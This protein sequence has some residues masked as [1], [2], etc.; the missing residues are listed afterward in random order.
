MKPFSNHRTRRRIVVTLL[1]VWFFAL[2]AGWANACLL[3][4]RGTHWHVLAESGSAPA[5]ASHISAG[6]LGAGLDH[7]AN[8]GLTKS[9][10]LKVCGDSAQ[11]VVKAAVSADVTDVGMTSPTVLEW[12]ATLDAAERS[13]AWL[14]SPDPS[15]GVPLRTRFSRLAL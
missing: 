12:F 4:E 5:Q 2:G 11:T 7:A 10:C 14:D 6:H 9:A 1:L 3:Q 13:N 15:P 8:A